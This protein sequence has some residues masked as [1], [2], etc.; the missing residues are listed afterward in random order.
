MPRKEKGVLE[1]SY[2]C[3]KP[4]LQEKSSIYRNEFI[5]HT[6]TSYKVSRSSLLVF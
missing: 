4:V 3:N 6:S 2:G 1:A 5:Q